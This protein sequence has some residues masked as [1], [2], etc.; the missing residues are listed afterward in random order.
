MIAKNSIKRQECRI[1]NKGNALNLVNEKTVCCIWWGVFLL[2]SVK[3]RDY[4][5]SPI[6]LSRYCCQCFFALQ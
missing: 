4:G 5:A 3:V 1:S 2:L 6:S